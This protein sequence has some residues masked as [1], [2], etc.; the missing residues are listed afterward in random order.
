MF[1]LFAKTY[2]EWRY[3]FDAPFFIKSAWFI[4]GKRKSYADHANADQTTRISGTLKLNKANVYWVEAYA[5]DLNGDVC[6]L[7][8]A[9]IINRPKVKIASADFAQQKKPGIGE[10]NR[11]VG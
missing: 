4:V 11:P 7:G 6:S 9:L 8:R 1:F 3:S 10:K 2:G 5:Q